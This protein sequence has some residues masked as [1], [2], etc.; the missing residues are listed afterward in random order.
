MAR[1][2]MVR[3]MAVH[4]IENPEEMKHFNVLGYAFSE[5][6]SSGREYVFLRNG[7]KV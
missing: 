7:R 3:Y 5:E 6:L 1:G 4:N 2:E